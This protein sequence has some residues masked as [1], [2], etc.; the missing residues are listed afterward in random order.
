MSAFGATGIGDSSILDDSDL[1]DDDDPLEGPTPEEEKLLREVMVLPL[2]QFAERVATMPLHLRRLALSVR[3]SLDNMKV[4]RPAP[5]P[6]NRDAAY[7]RLRVYA[8]QKAMSA[9]ASAAPDQPQPTIVDTVKD[10]VKFI[11]RKLAERVERW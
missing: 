5:G 9:F 10:A 3:R 2:A 8:I 6:S 4:V 7:E 1:S 11:A